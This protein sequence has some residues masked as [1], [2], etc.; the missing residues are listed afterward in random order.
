MAAGTMAAKGQAYVAAWPNA[1]AARFNLSC[2]YTAEAMQR[3]GIIT[4]DADCS[5]LRS[6]FLKKQA[7]P[8][9][10]ALNP[11]T[12]RKVIAEL[13]AIDARIRKA[14]ATSC[15][16]CGVTLINGACPACG[17]PLL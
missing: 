4:S 7:V 13:A 1:M 6:A 15:H 11:E 3:A 12:A 10:A 14:A 2:E 16:C 9:V 17:E 8:E 5:R